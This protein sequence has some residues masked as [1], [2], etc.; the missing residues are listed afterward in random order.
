M[1]GSARVNVACSARGI[2]GDA[3]NSRLGAS[4]RG[5]MGG[6]V[7]TSVGATAHC[8]VGVIVRRSMGAPVDGRDCRRAGAT[9][10]E[11]VGWSLGCSPISADFSTP[12]VW[13]RPYREGKVVAGDDHNC[14][15]RKKAPCPNM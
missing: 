1:A 11:S 2:V 5:S 4:V 8:S 6:R 14:C 3:M 10:D 9:L 12:R 13:F 7:G 15:D